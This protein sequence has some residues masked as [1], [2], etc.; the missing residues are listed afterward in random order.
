[1]KIDYYPWKVKTLVD[2]INT[3]KLNYKSPSEFAK[4][5]GISLEVL[6]SWT[7]SHEPI[8]TLEQL[9]LLANYRKWTLA[10]VLSWLNIAST[11]LDYLISNAVDPLFVQESS[12]S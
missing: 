5:I 7:I 6:L 4:A 10:E 12:A 1:M 11:H 8:I 9:Y 3:E 2:W